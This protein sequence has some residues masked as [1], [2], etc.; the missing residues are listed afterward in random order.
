MADPAQQVRDWLA[1][2][3][4]AAPAHL[5]CDR[6][7]PDRT[8]LVQVDADLSARTLTYGQLR[9]RS[10]A[11]A[12]G[13]TGL[14]VTAATPVA[15]L[16]DRGIDFAVTALAVWRLGATLVPLTTALAPSAISLRLDWAKAHIVVCEDT[17]LAKL[18]AAPA[19]TVV[20]TAGRA[21]PGRHTLD[22]LHLP[23]PYPEAA[24]T[25]APL[26]LLYTSGSAGPPRAVSVPQRA[27]VGLHSHH[28]YGLDVGD[29]D[30][31]WCTGDPGQADGLYHALIAP[32]LAGHAPLHL[33]AGFD[34]ELT[35]DVME[36]FGVTVF[37]A[38]PTVYR[39]LR[40]TTKTLPPEIVVRS[41]ASTGETPHADVTQWALNTFGIP[42]S[43]HYGRPETGVVATST[44]TE[45]ALS[46]LPGFDLR[47]L[48]PGSDE[49]A[50]AGEFGR[51]A[52]HTT[53]PALWFDGYPHDPTASARRFSPDHR[54][55]LTGDTGTTTGHGRV[56]LSTRDD[57]VI[58]TRGYR[59]GPY[60]VETAL[61]SH[62]DVEEAAVYGVP[63]ATHGALVAANIVLMPHAGP[64]EE[65]V[66]D[67]QALVATT[68]AAHAA[69]QR[70]MF[71]A[72]LPK[73]ASGKLRRN[74]LSSP[75]T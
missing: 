52:L 23:G 18:P 53:S 36:V 34:P 30:V 4:H 20:T 49:P 64:S 42:I 24:A 59:V 62:P 48:Q 3:P 46:A 51:V 66:E 45:P 19:A 35:L 72:Q 29:D 43:D 26:A 27:L 55:Y 65:L 61:L 1:A 47:V 40:S 60:D 12:A 17:H 71:V 5:L 68:L 15:T 38:T 70:V 41:L 9:E 21:A 2:Y 8:A 16:M 13:L 44:G 56:V 63:D 54:W 32:L 31:Y 33:R 7:D 58:T 11:L 39:A 37:V 50:P 75:S 6:H 73:T 67:L 74:R 69:P 28:R 25:G 14:G 10:Q 57:G 22:Q